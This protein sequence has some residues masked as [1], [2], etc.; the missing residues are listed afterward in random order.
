MCSGPFEDYV[1]STWKSIALHLYTDYPDAQGLYVLLH[2]I[3]SFTMFRICLNAGLLLQAEKTFPEHSDSLK[4]PD[5]LVVVT[6]LQQF[7]Q[8]KQRQ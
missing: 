2:I 7:N 4:L 5:S 8:R 6:S 1:G 3:V